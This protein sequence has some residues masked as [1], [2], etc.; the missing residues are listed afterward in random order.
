MTISGG[1][2]KLLSSA[3]ERSIV[4]P[5]GFDPNNPDLTLLSG[6][7]R[8]TWDIQQAFLK[9]YAKCGSVKGAVRARGRENRTSVYSWEKE[10][11]LGFRERFEL[12]RQTYREYLEDLALSRIKGP[13]GNRG[14]DVLLMFLLKAH[15]PE[16]YRE[17]RV[18]V[19]DTPKR[20]MEMLTEMMKDRD[21]AKDTQPTPSRPT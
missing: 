2:T 17:G 20:V 19:D 3:Q 7:Q 18:S 15:W 11:I 6:R 13:T 8:R 21:R 1:T 16:K 4:R 14:S 5:M 9:A 10:D 12:A